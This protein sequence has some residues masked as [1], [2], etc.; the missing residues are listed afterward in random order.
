MGNEIVRFA[1]YRLYDAKKID[2]SN[3]MMGLLAGAQMASH[4]LQLTEGSETRLPD[5]FP[6]VQH[7]KPF[8]VPTETVRQVLQSAD[9]HLGAISVPYSL[10]LH[11][12]FLKTCV[13]L[14]VRG[15]MMTPAQALSKT[16]LAV[17]HS[18]IE[19][20]TGE[21]FSP[22]SIIQVDTLRL[23]RSCMIHNGGR[24]DQALVDQIGRW[25]PSAEARWVKLTKSSLRG[26]AVGDPVQFGHAELILCL[27]VTKSLARQANRILRDALPR[28]LWATMVVEDVLSEHPRS[29]PHQLERLVYGQARRHYKPLQLTEAE[30]STAIAAR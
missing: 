24:A 18:A 23:M 21:S 10:E 11:E 4:L 27:A 9:N 16:T 25:T 15:R 17:L 7:V 22:D 1:E 29:S 12:D 28:P 30:L 20:A 19:E 8:N 26:L 2:A 3:A 5:V 14:L 6:Q 13:D